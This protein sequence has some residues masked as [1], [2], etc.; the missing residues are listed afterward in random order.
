[1]I[2]P[3][4]RLRQL[5]WRTKLH[6]SSGHWIA[7]YV[8]T[9]RKALIANTLG[10]DEFTQACWCPADVWLTDGR[11]HTQGRKLGEVHLV[12]GDYGA[13]VVAHELLHALLHWSWLTRFPI[14]AACAQESERAQAANEA[15][16]DELGTLVAE[17]WNAYYDHYSP[18]AHDPY[19]RNE[20]AP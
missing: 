15:L 13:G 10:M 16:C 3:R 11:W 5:A 20:T 2:N 6:L 1:L 17:F 7:V 8:W 18:G 19:Q 12:A 9:G 4:K 14:R